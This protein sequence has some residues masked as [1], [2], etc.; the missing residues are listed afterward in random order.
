MQGIG[1]SN[2]R[3]AEKPE[4]GI[5]ESTQKLSTAGSRDHPKGWRRQE[6]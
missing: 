6:S 2:D 3:R 1:Y 5:S 4:K